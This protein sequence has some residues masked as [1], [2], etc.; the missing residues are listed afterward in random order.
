MTDLWPND[1]AEIGPIKAPITILKE[2]ASALGEKTKNIL[3]G[4]VINVSEM[5]LGDPEVHRIRPILKGA[6]TYMFY[7]V[8]ITIGYR[9][10]LLVISHDV[11][12]YPLSL[13]VED[14]I[15]QQIS[16][17]IPDG[18]DDRLSGIYEVL[19]VKSEENFLKAL[20]E[21]FGSTKV[22]QVIQAI[23]LQAG[24]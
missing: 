3:K 6:F 2:Q 1:I 21:I 12:L 18:W 16:F 17:E 4:E 8:G 10:R 5:G 7:I 20:K 11:E 23:L 24:V 19:T 13:L 22:R 15:K 14:D 9:Y